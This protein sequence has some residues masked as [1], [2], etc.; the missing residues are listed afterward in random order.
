MHVQ[1]FNPID[2]AFAYDEHRV[3]QNAIY[4]TTALRNS[5]YGGILL[6][7]DKEVWVVYDSEFK[8]TYEKASNGSINGLEEVSSEPHFMNQVPV[9]IYS[10][11]SDQ[12][13]FI[14][15]NLILQQDLYNVVANSGVD[16]LMFNIEAL[17][18]ISG[19]KEDAM[20]D[21]TQT[22]EDVLTENGVIINES[23][24]TLPANTQQTTQQGVGNSV[25]EELKEYGLLMLDD[26]KA[27]AQFLT[28]GNESEKIDFILQMIRNHV[29][30]TAELVDVDL[31]VGTTGSTSGIALELK[32]TPQR[33]R[34]NDFKRYLSIGLKN[35][36]DAI[37]MLLVKLNRPIFDGIKITYVLNIPRNE[38]ELWNSIEKQMLLLSD[39][40]I[41]SQFGSVENPTLAIQRKMK[42]DLE[43]KEEQ[44]D[45]NI[46]IKF[47]NN[48]EEEEPLEDLDEKDEDK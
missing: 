39:V 12:E 1:N 25:I 19:Y 6:E 43:R 21:R 8:T 26:E 30:M 37:N 35:R 14:T 15:D 28:K 4:K 11:N 45:R 47:A 46:N 7:Q 34:A 38:N 13:S 42:Q 24:T 20:F 5:Y 33:N 29:H 40:D 44:L 17:L 31:I 9:I 32:Y 36:I 27:T 23:G 48:D 2:W 3:L 18:V 22:A 16:D 41:L 10:I